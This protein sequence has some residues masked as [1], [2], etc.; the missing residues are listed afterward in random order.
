MRHARNARRQ[1]TAQNSFYP[2]FRREDEIEATARD[3]GRSPQTRE[4]D[5]AGLGKIG[6]K[7]FWC[8]T[9]LRFSLLESMVP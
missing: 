8:R 7:C 5:R 3:S 4:Q 9:V 6:S 1:G 2:C